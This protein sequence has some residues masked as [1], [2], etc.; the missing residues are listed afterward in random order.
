MAKV[1]KI[2]QLYIEPT[3]AQ[4][5]TAAENN[6]PANVFEGRVAADLERVFISDADDSIIEF[7]FVDTSRAAGTKQDRFAVRV[8]R[9]SFANVIEAEF[10]GFLEGKSLVDDLISL[11]DHPT[12]STKVRLIFKEE[13]R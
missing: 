11:D 4:V 7:R 6:G 3:K 10:A 13:E 9:Q 5:F 8:D 2:D 12:D 1:L